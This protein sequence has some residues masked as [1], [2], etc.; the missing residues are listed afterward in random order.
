MQIAI[1]RHG[2]SHGYYTADPI[3]ASILMQLQIADFFK[4]ETYPFDAHI[5]VIRR[6]DSGRLTVI[7]RQNEVY[8][9]LR[10]TI[11]KIDMGR[12]LEFYRH[13][14]RDPQQYEQRGRF[15]PSRP[16]TR[17]FSDILSILVRENE[18]S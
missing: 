4:K 5:P 13:Q 2:G 9:H 18:R 8:G 16:I 17:I 7:Q 11:D 15:P 14:Q 12:M 1:K 6:S 3:T 10:R